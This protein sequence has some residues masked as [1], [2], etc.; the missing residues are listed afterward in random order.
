MP[1]YERPNGTLQKRNPR[2]LLESAEQDWQRWDA[3]AAALGLTWSDFAR[4]AQ[5]KLA[6]EVLPKLKRKRKP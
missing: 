2:K 3:A 1:I 5:D 6:A 4:R